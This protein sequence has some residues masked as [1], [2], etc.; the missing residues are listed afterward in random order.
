MKNKINKDQLHKDVL[1]KTVKSHKFYK[2][3]PYVDLHPKDKRSN[4]DFD[5]S[6]N[7]NDLLYSIP[8]LIRS[9][10]KKSFSKA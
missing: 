9:N 7:I 6:A 2:Y 1:S 10:D 8:M 5:Q 3:D 4:Y